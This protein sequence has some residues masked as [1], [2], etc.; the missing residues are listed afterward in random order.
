MQSLFPD[1]GPAVAD[2]K[3]PL[4]IRRNVNGSGNSNHRT[5]AAGKVFGKGHGVTQ[6]FL[7]YPIGHTGVHP[8]GGAGAQD[9]SFDF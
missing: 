3:G 5:A 4:S 8:F 2:A 9:Q 7:R 1:P 6:V